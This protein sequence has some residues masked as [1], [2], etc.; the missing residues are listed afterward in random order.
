GLGPGP[1]LGRSSLIAPTDTIVRTGQELTIGD[2]QMVFQITPGTE[3]PAEM[4]FYLPQFRALFM[5]ENANLTMHNLLPARGALVRD[6][7]AWADY[8]T[9]AIRLF[10]DRSDV[11][12]AAHGI[13]R[14]GQSEIGEFLARHRD[15]YKF[16]HDQTIRLINIGLTASEI[17]EVLE[18]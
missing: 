3:A 4:N 1:S 15:A 7:K 9:E 18:L 16:L 17:A 8:L 6:C 5:A 12:F 2:M 13:P 14:F 11:M 10:A